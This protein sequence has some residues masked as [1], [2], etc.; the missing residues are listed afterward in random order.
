MRR[1][2]EERGLGL[3]DYA[4][5][6]K[7]E[8]KRMLK[9][10]K[11]G[12]ISLPDAEKEK[13]IREWRWITMKHAKL[14]NAREVSALG[15]T[16]RVMEGKK[17]GG[18]QKK[19]RHSEEIKDEAKLHI[20]A[21][22]ILVGL[23]AEEMNGKKGIL[24]EYLDKR[25]RWSVRICGEP[26]EP[27]AVQTSNLILDT[28]NRPVLSAK[29]KT[30]RKLLK[31]LRQIEQLEQAV[32]KGDTLERNQLDKMMKKAEVERELDTIRNAPP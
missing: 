23:D 1:S 10:A 11:R 9:Q 14:R 24:E 4:K 16:K 7:S 32:A 3:E 27:V 17:D 8:L 15:G 18:T 29:E 30:I 26:G 5:E 22:V 12:L 6:R 2:A 21:E 20:G 28:P 19:A 13:L 25:A 31:K